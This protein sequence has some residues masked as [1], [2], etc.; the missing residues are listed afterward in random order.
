HKWDRAAFATSRHLGRKRRFEPPW[1]DALDLFESRRTA[2]RCEQRGRIAVLPCIRVEA[3][4]KGLYGVDRAGGR[5]AQAADQT[6]GYESF[7]NVGARRCDKDGTHCAGIA[8]RSDRA[9]MRVCTTSAR[10]AISSLGCCAVNVRRRR[11]VPGG[12]VGGRMAVTRKPFSS[13]RA[14]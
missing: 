9:R 13:R 3:G 6:G 11:A 4:D 5:G 10:R 14:D 1:R 7:S 2:E 12:T 8:T